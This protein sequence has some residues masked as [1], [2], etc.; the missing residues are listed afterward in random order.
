MAIFQKRAE[1]ILKKIKPLQE[2]LKKRRV[3]M[4]NK[5]QETDRVSFIKKEIE[6]HANENDEKCRLFIEFHKEIANEAKSKP[7]K[8]LLLTDAI[9]LFS[10]I[11]KV[12]PEIEAAFFEANGAE[13]LAKTFETL[14]D[15]AISDLLQQMFSD[16]FSTVFKNLLNIENKPEP[17]P[18]PEP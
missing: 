2:D 11:C 1:K 5:K 7:E 13:G 14:L 10:Q 3:K 8:E 15:T 6:K 9:D 17:E 4:S 12:Y 18:E 16:D